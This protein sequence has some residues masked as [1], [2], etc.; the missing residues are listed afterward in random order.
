MKHLSPFEVGSVPERILVRHATKGVIAM[1]VNWGTHDG[2]AFV[3]DKIPIVAC[4]VDVCQLVGK[5]CTAFIEPHI[6]DACTCDAVAEPLMSKLM[7]DKVIHVVIVERDADIFYMLHAGTRSTFREPDF[8]PWIRAKQITE[9]FIRLVETTEYS[10]HL[11]IIH[12]QASH[13][14]GTTTVESEVMHLIGC[15][16]ETYLISGNGVWL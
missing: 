9:E 16:I 8:I 3:V 13:L 14:E 10:A 5:G 11:G 7:F 15:G 2:K 1:F 4:P 12:V 6:V